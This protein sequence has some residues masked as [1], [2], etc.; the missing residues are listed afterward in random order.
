[1]N[2][3]QSCYK[4]HTQE[5][6]QAIGQISFIAL[7]GHVCTN[8]EPTDYDDWRDQQWG[9]IDYPMIPH[10]WGVK[11]INDK[12]KMAILA[13][14]KQSAPQYDGIIVGTDSDVEGYG[15]YYLLEQYLGLGSKKALRFIEHSLTDKEILESLLSMTDFHSDPV[16]QRFVQSFL[17]RNRCDWLFGMNGTRCVTLKTNE[18][19]TVGRVKAPTLKIVYD[20]SMAIEHFKPETYYLLEAAYTKNGMPFKAV[21]TEDGVTPV[22]FKDQTKI[23]SYPLQGQVASVKTKRVTSGPPKLYDLSAIQSEAGSKYGYSPSQTLEIVQSLYETHKLISYP[24]TQCRYVSQEKAREFPQMLS[25]MS[26][27]EELRP[28]AAKVTDED[29]QRVYNNKNVVNDKEV[30]KES[31]DA[32]LPTSNRPDL[33]K[34]TAEEQ[35]ICRMIYTRLLAQFMPLL[36]EDKT[37]LIIQHGDGQFVAKGKVVVNPGWRNLYSALQDKELPAVSEGEML[38]ADTIAPAQK[39]TTPP[40]RLTQAT[41][42]A[43]MENIASQITDPLLKKSLADSK[44]IGTPATRANIIKDIIDRG[45]V[46]EKKK[47]LYITNAGK[48]YID[49]IK[50]LEIISP[51]FAAK[52]DTKIKE[53]QRGEADYEAAYAD[54]VDK[55]KQMVQQIEAMESVVPDLGVNCPYCGKPLQQSKYSYNCNGCGFNVGKNL[56]S[57]EDT[58]RELCTKRITGLLTMKKKDGSTFKARLK[59]GESGIEFDF[60]SGIQCPFCG[61]PSVKLNRGGA[62]CDCG[63][64]VFRKMS[65]KEFSD[66]ELTKLLQNGRLNKVSGFISK[67]GKPYTADI[68]LTENGAQFDTS[69]WNTD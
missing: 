5:I 37:T 33:S 67:K 63:L 26:V 7:A 47:Q 44:G 19:M 8:Y 4:N 32:L 48:R 35:N 28:Y 3:V 1:M 57:S 22:Q 2:D 53:V 15:I 52:M 16:H 66:S 68:I 65:S 46:E 29:I 49:A 58:L 12:R 27:F 56:C 55:L 59:L 9:N 17:L 24:R 10:V 60:S 36:E 11:P 38:T 25:F 50:D 51:V 34:L 41:L 42:L 30:Q 31:H 20:N 64:K 43:A 21:Y 69:G 39:V 61:N 54:A 40:K 18:I 6:Q 13:E 14:I 23:P 45:Y 62:F